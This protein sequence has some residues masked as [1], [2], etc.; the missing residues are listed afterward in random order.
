MSR[1]KR[2]KF[3]TEFKAETV[4]LIR[5]SGRSIGDISSPANYEANAETERKAA[6]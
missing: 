3:T 2:R 4:K 5:E 6:A 1:R